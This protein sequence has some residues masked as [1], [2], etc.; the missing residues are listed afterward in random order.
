MRW[1]FKILIVGLPVLFVGG[2]IWWAVGVQQEELARQHAMQ[3]FITLRRWGPQVLKI[4]TG[5]LPEQPSVVP[6][7]SRVAFV[8]SADGG[9]GPVV[10]HNLSNLPVALRATGEKDVTHVACVNYSKQALASC[11]YTGG[12]TVARTRNDATIRLVDLRARTVAATWRA[13]G[14]EKTCPSSITKRRGEALV[15]VFRGDDPNFVKGLF[16]VPGLFA[17]PR[18]LRERTVVASSPWPT[19]RKSRATSSTR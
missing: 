10:V 2:L 19:T 15:E 1:P 6:P 8:G 4:C 14:V 16:A 11:T 17:E 9:R 13:Q 5:K 12:I 18:L 3:Q 7:G